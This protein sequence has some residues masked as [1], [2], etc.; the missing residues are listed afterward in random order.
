MAGVSYDMKLSIVVLGV[1]VV[2]VAVGFVWWLH[3][4]R[5]VHAF[6]SVAA[7]VKLSR[8]G[9]T[10]SIPM[11]HLEVGESVSSAEL[12]GYLRNS[13]NL[14]PGARIG[15]VVLDN[16]MEA[17]IESVRSKLV[18]AGF[19]VSGVM[20]VGFITGPA[21]ARG[22]AALDGYTEQKVIVAASRVDR[23]VSASRRA[24]GG[25][26]RS[27]LLVRTFPSFNG[28]GE[29][30]FEVIAGVEIGRGVHRPD[31]GG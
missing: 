15:V 12:I 26:S 16:D 29:M 17:K 5:S 1:A 31:P 27:A 7:L 30:C 2:A 4:A 20:K 14:R 18:D 22:T 6:D 23:S 13:R 9:M 24:L 28:G 3:Q 19:K 11:S 10:V 25:A 8:L 21:G